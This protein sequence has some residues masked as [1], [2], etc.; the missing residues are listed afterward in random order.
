M[1]T[2]TNYNRIDSTTSK[3]TIII[4]STEPSRNEDKPDRMILSRRRCIQLWY[5]KSIQPF[6][7]VTVAQ[8]LCVI[9]ILVLTFSKPPVGIRDPIT[10]DIIDANTLENTYE[11]VIYLNGSYRPVVAVGNWQKACLAISRA[12]A[13]SMYPML[14]VVFVTKMKATQCFL[15]RTPLSMYL[16]ILNQAHEHHHHA[17]AYLAFDVWV[18]TLFHTLRWASQGNS[19]LLWTSAAGL[20]GLIAVIGTLLI[21]F[22]MMY[23]KD[24][25]SYE[26]RKG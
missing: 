12:S 8:I 23:C 22:P 16:T 11:G 26:V 18:H 17:G 13:F 6:W 4:P 14:V 15:G 9:Y 24:R 25:L 19:G 20:S 3:S 5:R 10:N 2:L 21:A 1:V 7:K